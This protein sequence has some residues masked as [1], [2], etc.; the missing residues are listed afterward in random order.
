MSLEQDLRDRSG[1]VCELCTSTTDLDI[2]AVPDSP[3]NTTADTH[4]FACG[5]CRTQ[6]QDAEQI[7]AN[8]W[9]CLNDSM[10]LFLKQETL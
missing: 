10:G 3:E 5:T 2:Y 8:H 4:I 7:E 1:N 6:L 9:R